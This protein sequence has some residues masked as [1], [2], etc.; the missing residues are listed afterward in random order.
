MAATKLGTLGPH[1]NK[2]AASALV[3]SS[4]GRCA[5]VSFAGAASSM[6]HPHL[7]V[8]D[9]VVAAIRA[10]MAAAARRASLH[11]A[12]LLATADSTAAA[13]LPPPRA[14]D[15]TRHAAPRLPAA[16]TGRGG[17]DRCVT[18]ASPTPGTSSAAW[19]FFASEWVVAA[20]ATHSV[21]AARPDIRI[22]YHEV[23]TT[24]AASYIVLLGLTPVRLAELLP[25]TTTG[26][27]AN[28]VTLPFCL[29]SRAGSMQ[30]SR[31]TSSTQVFWRHP[32]KLSYGVAGYS[33]SGKTGEAY[34]NAPSI[35]VSLK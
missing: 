13:P 11:G 32:M 6:G 31:Y 20:I 1:L 9:A 8:S 25:T 24:H 21:A 26:F 18:A 2:A 12:Y 28:E 33:T 23:Y 3:A 22:A 30:R 4:A 16:G 35:W 7:C 10:T 14:L 34:A 19:S 29:K 15:S 17:D 27:S 5:A